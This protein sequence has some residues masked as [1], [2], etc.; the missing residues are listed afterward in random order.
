VIGLEKGPWVSS[1]LG[2]RSSLSHMAPQSKFHLGVFLRCS[3]VDVSIG[4]ETGQ[5]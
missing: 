4:F 3:G 2:A 5:A 1:Y